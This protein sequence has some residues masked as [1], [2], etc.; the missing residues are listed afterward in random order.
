MT[1]RVSRVAL[2]AVVLLGIGIW[3]KASAQQQADEATIR[4]AN[5]VRKRIVTLSNYGVFDNISFG[6]QGST[7]VLRGQAS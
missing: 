5:E 7:I 3:G 4:L 1:T 2:T 6:I